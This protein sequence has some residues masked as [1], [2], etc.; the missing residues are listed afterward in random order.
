[1]SENEECA[2]WSMHMRP[3]LRAMNFSYCY[4]RRN[5]KGTPKCVRAYSTKT[6]LIT[7]L[8]LYFWVILNAPHFFLSELYEILQHR[9][10]FS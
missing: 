5:Y 10:F 8:L 1:M 9:F 2:L 3:K 7:S 4:N 6:D